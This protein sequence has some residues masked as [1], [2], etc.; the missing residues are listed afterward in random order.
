MT[1]EEEL[2]EL[3]KLLRSLPEIQPREG[4]A[5]RIWAGV[6]RRLREEERRKGMRRQL[7]TFAVGMV[8]TMALLAWAVIYAGSRDYDE[9]GAWDG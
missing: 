1:V 5:E 4:A 6:Q 9:W 3:T 8:V 2:A 7:L